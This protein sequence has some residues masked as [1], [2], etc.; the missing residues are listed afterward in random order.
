M[1]DTDKE[2]AVKPR[3]SHFR[4]PRVLDRDY[5]KRGIPT[6]NDLVPY[7]RNDGWPKIDERGSLLVWGSTSP[8][9]RG[10]KTLCEM[11]DEDGNVVVSA[12][13]VCSFAD[14]FN[15]KMGRR[16]AF[17]RAMSEYSEGGLKDG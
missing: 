12:S 4:V 3:Y 17:G 16:I 14:N 13:S 5:P 15:Y 10:G 9:E 6:S 1:I 8:Y 7:S 2:Y 11:V